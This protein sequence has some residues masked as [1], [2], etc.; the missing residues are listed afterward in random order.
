MKPRKGFFVFFW[1][2]LIIIAAMV[3]PPNLAEKNITNLVIFSAIFVFLLIL[4]IVLFCFFF[5]T[6]K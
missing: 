6:E 2:F 3:I 4:S 5:K 1:T